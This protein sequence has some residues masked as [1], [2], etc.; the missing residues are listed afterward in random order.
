M[1][2]LLIEDDPALCH[3]LASKLAEQGFAVDSTQAGVDGAYMGESEPYD[4]IILDLGLPDMPGLDIL[5]QWRAKQIAIPVLILT[6][7]GAWHEKVEGFRKGADDYLTKP[8]HFEELLV[9]LQALIRRSSGVSG[10]KII[11]GQLQLDEESQSAMWNDEHDQRDIELTGIEF[12][13][14]RYMMLHPKRVFSATHLVEHVYDFNDEKE[15]NV[16]EVYISRLRKKLGK[17][18]ICTRRG[19]GYFLNPD[20]LEAGR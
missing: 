13:L 17:E 14:L 6:A 8:F 4:I 16:I 10:A 7:R 11:I 19:Q 20:A 1:R 3:E 2:L 12:R 15:S 18:V 9:R 5:A